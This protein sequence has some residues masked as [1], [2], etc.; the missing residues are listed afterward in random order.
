MSDQKHFQYSGSATMRQ[1]KTTDVEIKE[2]E[3]LTPARMQF[4]INGEE[5]YLMISVDIINRKAYCEK[6][7]DFDLSKAVFDFLDR[8]NSLPE[9]FFAIS[10][11]L[12]NIAIETQMEHDK[13]KPQTLGAEYVGTDFNQG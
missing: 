5:Q 3:F 6:H 13:I 4:N 10:G 1:L 8:A 7:L 11:D 12:A 2:V 9:D